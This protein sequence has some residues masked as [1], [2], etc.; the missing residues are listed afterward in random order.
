[1]KALCSRLLE[2]Y[3]WLVAET[4]ERMMMDE[5]EQQYER[6]WRK[7]APFALEELAKVCISNT[8]TDM[9]QLQREETQTPS[10]QCQ[11]SIVPEVSA[12]G[13]TLQVKVCSE[14]GHPLQHHAA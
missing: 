10:G 11:L 7:K 8:P 5:V 14:P 1:M 3:H 2:A 9:R 13:G 12:E 6:E 4:R